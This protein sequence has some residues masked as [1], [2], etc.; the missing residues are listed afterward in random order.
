MSQSTK[1]YLI[2]I[3][4]ITFLSTTAIFI[5]HLITFYK[6]PPLLI[7]FWRNV[8]VC[9]AL[10]PI[11]WLIRPNLLRIEL[12]QIHYYGF[13]GLILAL[14]NSIWVLSVEANGAAVS[15]VLA[16]SSAGFTA[17]FAWWIFKEPLGLF[18]MAAV[19]LTMT[20]S[21]LVAE[22][23][24][25][26]MWNLEPL[27][28]ITGVMSGVLFAGYNLMGKETARRKINPWT[29]LLYSF[30]FGSIFIFIFNLFPA[31]PG[32]AGS[33]Q[34]IIPDIPLLAWGILIFL[35]FVP[36]LIGFGLYNSSLNFLPASIVSILATIEPIMTAL[37][38]YV[39]LGERMTV[40]QII[41]SI[42][43]LAGVLTV[44][45]EKTKRSTLVLDKKL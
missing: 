23:Y 10:A 38:A 29:A 31:I 28:I 27:G 34:A 21:V 25:I 26:E 45:L 24:S 6:M 39:I 42:I 22:A 43:I 1:G 35:S 37:E 13:Y 36:T 32:T 14:F 2:A 12:K 5:A 30:A 44:R 7:A 41:G 8:L 40:I 17:L 33:I 3:V 4:A 9:V 11:L 18:K 19:V 20:G 16:Y 15:T